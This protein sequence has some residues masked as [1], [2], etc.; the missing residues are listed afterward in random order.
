[1]PKPGDSRDILHAIV[2][3]YADVFVTEDGEFRRML[4]RVPVTGFQAVNLQTLLSILPQW[5]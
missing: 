3:S 4:N 2:G 5:I 1:M